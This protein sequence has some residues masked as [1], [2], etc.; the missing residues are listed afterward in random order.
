M[1]IT[2]FGL[3]AFSHI[4]QAANDLKLDSNGVW[5]IRQMDG[6]NPLI[7]G[8]FSKQK[9]SIRFH[10]D[11]KVSGFG[12]CNSIFG[13][14]STIQ[15]NKTLKFNSLGRTTR[16]CG[17][18]ILNQE[19]TYMDIL[20]DIKSYQITGNQLILSTKKG[21]TLSFD[22][23]PYKK[24]NNKL[25]GKKWVLIGVEIF[26]GMLGSSRYKMTMYFNNGKFVA[27]TS[28]NTISGTY[29][30]S[31][32]SLKFSKIRRTEKHCAKYMKD[33]NQVLDILT[34]S[35]T[36]ELTEEHTLT[37]KTSDKKSLMFNVRQ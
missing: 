28:C 34:K 35:K 37:I 9:L 8:F 16:A 24:Y 15:W 7:G 20:T 13:K 25:T 5:V 18:A 17:K 6:K 30:S 36:F 4:S 11:G 22:F 31:G 29:T 12:G 2:L 10:S 19:K 27:Y 1:L 3:L 32:K 21:R 26:E 33:E 23:Q 14:Y